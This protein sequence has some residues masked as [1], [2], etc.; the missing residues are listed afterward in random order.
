MIN[1]TNKD[2]PISQEASNWGLKQT[3]AVVLSLLFIG[4]L[5]YGLFFAPAIFMDDWT[6]VI[7][8]IV[9]NNAQW[10]D[11]TQ[12]RPLLFSTFLL[13]N[14][15]FGLNITAYYISL[16]FLYIVMAL[17]LYL[18]IARLP[19]HFSNLF[20]FI[21]AALFLVFPTNYTHMWLIMF[22][23]YCATTL[24]LLYGYLLLRFSQKGGWIIYAL[25]L[26]CLL[27]PLGIYE[28]QLGVASTWALILF[29]IYFRQNTIAK[30]IGLL[31]PVILMGIYALWRT[32]GYQ[33]AG[34]TDQYL[35]QV[36]TSPILLLSRLILGYKITLGWGWTSAVVDFIPWVSSAKIAVLML[37]IIV[38]A[39][40]FTCWFVFQ[41]KSE[42]EDA[43][44]DTWFGNER[45]SNIYPYLFAVMCGFI[46][47]GAGYFPT[48]TVFLPSLSGIGSRFNI[49]ATIGG[50]VTITA[51]LMIISILISGNKEQVKYYFLISTTP[52]IIIGIFL[53]AS[54]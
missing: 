13:Q 28:G 39:L 18:I 14:Q 31:I 6:S 45:R 29:V 30:R 50:A 53:N 35:S 7:E 11:T 33:A 32:F 20:G 5:A 47:I 10:L 27:I 52:F 12:R 41:L 25:A 9:T 2:L 48:I 15:L 54:V 22:G 51:L 19:L 26:I 49:F 37:I 21:T 36:V 8:R 44:N 1:K 34:V 38:S 24:T 42:K 3:I 16:W 40:L 43:N 46:L 4:Y 23:V 17:L